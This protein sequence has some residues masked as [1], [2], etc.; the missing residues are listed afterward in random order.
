MYCFSVSESVSVDCFFCFLFWGF[1]FFLFLVMCHIFLYFPMSSNF[2]DKMDIVGATGRLILSQ[3][4]IL[5][6]HSFRCLFSRTRVALLLRN[7]LPSIPT[8]HKR[9]A[10]SFHSGYQN[11]NIY[12]PCTIPGISLQVTAPW[13]LLSARPHTVS[14]YTYAAQLS[15]RGLRT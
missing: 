9:I 13:Q 3:L 10:R 2:Q 8:E 1:F 14:I 15:G 5:S 11:T 4:L 6:W 12:L 7:G